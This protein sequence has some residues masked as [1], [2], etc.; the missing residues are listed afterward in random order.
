MN[1]TDHTQR[2]EYAHMG[3]STHK[4][5]ETHAHSHKSSTTALYFC[6]GHIYDTGI[7]LSISITYKKLKI[8]NSNRT[9]SEALAIYVFFLHSCS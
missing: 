9:D 5:M 7:S 6:T 8:H 3:F 2:S 1:H 4:Q